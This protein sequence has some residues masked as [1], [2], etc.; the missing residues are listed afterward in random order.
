MAMLAGCSD[1]RLISNEPVVPGSEVRFTLGLEHG[2]RTYYAYPENAGGIGVDN[3]TSQTWAL[4]WTNGDRVNIF[5]PD[6]ASPSSPYRITVPEDQ[7]QGYNYATGITSINANGIQWGDTQPS[8]ETPVRFY[9]VFPQNYKVSFGELGQTVENSMEKTGETG[10]PVRANLHIRRNQIVMFTKIDTHEDARIGMPI[11]RAS[12]TDVNACQNNPDAIMYAQTRQTAGGDVKL[13][14]KPLSTVLHIKVADITGGSRGDSAT[15]YGFR[16]EAPSGVQLAGDFTATF[17]ADCETDPEIAG[18]RQTGDNVIEVST[19]NDISGHY[20]TVTTG[21]ERAV[22]FNVFIVPQENLN[23]DGWTLTCRTDYGDFTTTLSSGTGQGASGALKPGQIHNMPLAAIDVKNGNYDLTPEKWMEDI[24][25]N[26]YVTEL[27]I[28]GAWY[29]TTAAYQ[30]SGVTV[31][32]LYKAGVRAFSLETRSSGMAWNDNPG[33]PAQ[34]VVSGTQSNQS[35]GSGCY[36]GTAISTVIT[37]IL[38]QVKSTPNEFAVLL[39]SYAD[40]GDNGHRQTDYDFWLGGVQAQIQTAIESVGGEYVFGY[41]DGKTFGPSTTVGDVRGKLIIKVN[42]DE[43]FKG[44]TLPT[45]GFP[46]VLAYTSYKWVKGGGEEDLPVDQRNLPLMSHG[47]WISEWNASTDFTNLS[48]ADWSWTN[49]SNTL[50]AHQDGLH[51]AYTNANRT[52]H[53][54]DTDTVTTNPQIP[55]SV[56]RQKS[57]STLVNT[58]QTIYQSGAHNVWFQIGAGGTLATDTTSA[59]LTRGA[60]HVA[61]HFNQFFYNLI[62]AKI[63]RNSPSPLGIVLCNYISRNVAATTT[64]TGW[65]G[66]VT[67]NGTAVGGD[68]ENEFNGTKLIEQ[69]L[70]MNNLF[71][72]QRDPNWSPDTGSG[73]AQVQSASPNHASGFK[74][75][76]GTWSVF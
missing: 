16:I 11:D 6:L 34:V 2:S 69:I 27:T 58:S 47:R 45:T 33:T 44:T 39:L 19:L 56:E 65:L 54:E 14:Y 59:T 75:S 8:E 74:A 52:F 63:D 73:E 1:E 29:A 22:E 3:T 4:F 50:S 15:V 41:S 5:S 28:P 26:V 7:S 76:P 64:T 38:N 35:A 18:N 12:N 60:E 17:N 66:N 71:Y 55:T 53:L 40:G 57:I 42:M 24:P 31:D 51:F 48:G 37:S 25:D 46:V 62:R 20:L 13:Q 68:Y 67:V 43:R 49:I 70:L 23:V 30:G 61:V 21:D 72:L 36:G 9:S 10:T 32:S